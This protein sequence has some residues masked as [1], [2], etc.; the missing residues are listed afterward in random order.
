MNTRTR[1]R[2]AGWQRGR[3]LGAA[4]TCAAL[5]A[6]GCGSPS[7]NS[8]TNSNDGGNSAAQGGNTKTRYQQA[9]AYAHCV[10]SHGY[11]AFPDPLP[12]GAYP[13]NGTLDLSSPQ[14]KT[15]A[16]ECKNLEPPPNYSQYQAGYQ[17]LLRYSACMRQ[18]GVLDY[19]DP[20]LSNNGVTISF[21]R[22]TGPGEVN[23]RSPQFISAEAKCRSFQPGGGNGGQQ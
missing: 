22:G 21:K 1:G 9:V 18:N 13:N 8:G 16:R 23:T 19:P 5:L 11:P 10:R 2:H 15:A 20:V 3:I 12:N 4:V 14:F 17:A 6:T 7:S